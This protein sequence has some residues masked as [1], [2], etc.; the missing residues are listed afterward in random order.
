MPLTQEQRF[1]RAMLDDI[2][3][4]RVAHGDEPLPYNEREHGTLDDEFAPTTEAEAGEIFGTPDVRRNGK[5]SA[6][7]GATPKVE[8]FTLETFAEL[9]SQNETVEYLV[10]GIIGENSLTTFFGPPGVGKSFLIQWLCICVALGIEFFGRAVRQAPVLYAAAEGIPGIPARFRTIAEALGVNDV[11]DIR[12][13]RRAV[14]LLDRESQDALIAAC[15]VGE[16]DPGLVVFDTLQAHSPPAFNESETQNMSAMATAA[17]RIMRE[18]GNC[19]FVFLHHPGHDLSR[20]RGS[21]VLGGT[22]D[23]LYAVEASG[24]KT[25]TVR[26]RKQRDAVDPAPFTLRIAPFGESARLEECADTVTLTPFQN[27]QLTALAPRPLK[28]AEWRNLTGHVKSTFNSIL[29]ELKQAEYVSWDRRTKIY[30]ITD[31]GLEALGTR[32]IAGTSEVRAYPGKGGT[33]GTAVSIQPY[34]VPALGPMDQEG[35]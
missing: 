35:A 24:E 15:P 4:R 27:R 7:G 14:D 10:T 28:W 18:L 30:A 20:P 22:V 6:N 29:A 26:S 3:R 25:F 11:P 17:R 23:A 19:A 21:S 12:F 5:K 8:P 13:L 34:L 9:K 31:K 1:E 32:S 16:F 33:S 2:N